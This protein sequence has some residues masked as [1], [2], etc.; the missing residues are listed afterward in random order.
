MQTH[1]RALTLGDTGR[2]LVNKKVR[3]NHFF[4]IFPPIFTTDRPTDPIF[5][6]KMTGNENIIDDRLTVREYSKLRDHPLNKGI[7]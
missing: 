6:A 5:Q 4:D 7:P 3:K 1:S 2:Y